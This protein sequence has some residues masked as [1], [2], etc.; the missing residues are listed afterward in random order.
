MSTRIC[1]VLFTLL[2]VTFKTTGQEPPP[3]VEAPMVS[4][5]D[6]VANAAEYHG[7]VV[8][9]RAIYR[10]SFEQSS[11]EAPACKD[12]R[13]WISFEQRVETATDPAVLRRWARAFRSSNRPRANAIVYPLHEVDVTFL[14]RFS[15]IKSSAKV[16]GRT[17]TYGFGHLNAFDYALTVVRIE[18][19]GRSFERTL[20]EFENPGTF[21]ITPDEVDRLP[22]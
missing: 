11:F 7:K 21:I 17:Y 10:T 12:A 18:R 2:C 1:T 15:G 3:G 5:C 14:A 9:V 4:L 13:V 6:L 20:A 19:V 22:F 8:R 16:G